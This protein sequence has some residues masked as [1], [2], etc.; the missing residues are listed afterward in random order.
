MTTSTS[1][2]SPVRIGQIDFVNLTPHAIVFRDEQGVDH[3]VPPSGEIARIGSHTVTSHIDS[4]S[5][6]VRVDALNPQGWANFV[7][8]VATQPS[9]DPDQRI[10]GVVSSMFLDHLRSLILAQG[11]DLEMWHRL[12]HLLVSPLTDGTAIR[13]EKG[14]IIA[15]RSFRTELFP[16]EFNSIGLSRD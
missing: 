4:L 3:T 14:H 7:N 11:G 15:V 6:F 10:V 2:F 9:A 5:M 1:S 13:N 12:L 8:W 16:W